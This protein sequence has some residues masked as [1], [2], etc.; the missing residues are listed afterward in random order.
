MVWKHFRKRTKSQPEEPRP[1]DTVDDTS[2]G[3]VGKRR[4]PAH[5]ASHVQDQKRPS[6]PGGTSPDPVQRRLAAMK[7]QRLAMLYDIEQGELAIAD[8]N[9]WKN[10]IDLLT[11]AIGTVSDDLKALK[12]I[13]TGPYFPLP[14]SPIV[15][16]LV[17]AEPVASVRF[18]VGAESFEY[19]EDPDWAERGHQ[20]IRTELIPREGDPSRLLPGDVPGELREPLHN[21]LADSLFVFASD[22]RDRALDAEPM[23]G[24]PTLADLARPCPRCGGWTDWRGTCQACAARA[25]EE[26]ALKREEVRLLDERAHEAEEQ[27]RL[28]ERLPLARRRLRDID[29]QIAALSS[30]QS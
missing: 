8:D 14:A 22:L 15:V 1:P 19:A 11:Q 27:H 17:S 16:D 6:E 28:A 9:P 29:T 25:A 10:R 30:E 21:H 4:L 24:S 5:L 2:P 3:T 23:P 7:R 12:T 26:V 18:T 13:P 20:V